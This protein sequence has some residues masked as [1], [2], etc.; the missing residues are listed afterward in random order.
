MTIF[1]RDSTGTL[2][3]TFVDIN[4]DAYVPSDAKIRIIH[5]AG[6]SEIEDVPLTAMTQINTTNQFYFN[7]DIADD[8]YLGEYLI[9]YT[10]TID[11]Y[12]ST[13]TE[14]VQVMIDQN[15]TPAPGTYYAT[16]LQITRYA[17]IGVEVQVESLG[18]GDGTENSYNAE[19]GNIV[20]SSY[21]IF[22]GDVG[23]NELGELVETTHYSID[24]DSGAI[25]LT[26]TG[27][28][29]VNGKSIYISYTYS[30]KQSDTVLE[31]YLAP[32]Q[33]EAEKLTAN[34]WGPIKTSIQYFDGYSSGYVHTDAPFGTDITDQPEFELKYSGIKTVEA[35]EFLDNTGDVQN[36]VEAEY[37]RL[38][39]DDEYQ[40]GRVIV[41]AGSIPNGKNNVRITYTHGYDSTPDL[42]Q[43]MIA[44][45]GGVR[46]LVNISGGS[47]KDVS[48]Y[49]LGRKSFSI[50]QVYV[51]IESSIKQMKLRV[52]EITE[53][54]GEKF[55]C[56]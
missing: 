22:Y 49:S 16:T 24:K 23:S 42:V 9:T 36:D 3:A 39:I 32:S 10:A 54:L 51:N 37:I 34:Y 7:W 35:V 31:T 38:M 33:V 19:N 53:E 55:G 15:P 1:E 8:A 29:L 43:E 20:G 46:A 26:T 27:V 30:P 28:N 13:N 48:T 6:G 4:G 5:I 41:T 14:T 11:T 50:G 2:Y 45:L 12:P 56:A 47:Y 18:T 17:G 44:L 52:K 40:D 25:L 21:S